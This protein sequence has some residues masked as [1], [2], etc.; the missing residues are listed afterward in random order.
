MH[1][2]L[3]LIAVVGAVLY[4]VFRARN[5]AHAA[6]ELVD[7]ADDVRAAVRRFGFS[8]KAGQ[9]PADTVTDPRLAAAGCLAALARMDGA[10]TQAQVN[11][12]RVEARAS[13][14]VPQ[15]EAD[16]IAAYGRWLADQSNTPDDTL[17]R[18]VRVIRDQAPAEAHQDFIAMCERIAAVEGGGASPVQLSAIT[19]VRDALGLRA[20]R[21]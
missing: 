3:A 19:R 12:L 20:G 14:R 11:A 21:A 15:A 5:A 8:R 6:H 7:V 4:W 10:L 17:R 16:E 2:L 18:L 1:I 13:F 9:H